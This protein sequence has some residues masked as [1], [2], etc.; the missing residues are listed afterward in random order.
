MKHPGRGSW[1]PDGRWRHG[2]K[3]LASLHDS[4]TTI[5][6]CLK[7]GIGKSCYAHV[8]NVYCWW[9]GTLNGWDLT[10]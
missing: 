7:L 4:G 3:C 6:S 5:A 1:S 8:N 10:L 2:D 9:G